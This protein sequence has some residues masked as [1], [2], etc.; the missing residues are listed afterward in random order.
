MGLV[1]D[2]AGLQAVVQQVRF[3]VTEALAA[4][5]LVAQVEALVV[6][7]LVVGQVVLIAHLL[8]QAAQAVGA[9]GMLGVM[10]QFPTLSSQAEAAVARQVQDRTEPLLAP[11]T[12]LVDLAGPV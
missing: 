9:L 10:L 4:L 1:L 12:L 3:T 5:I 7:E 8:A 2:Q 11:K 6:G